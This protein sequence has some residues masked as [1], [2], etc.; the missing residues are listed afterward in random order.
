MLFE[1]WR[2]GGDVTIY[3]TSARHTTGYQRQIVVHDDIIAIMLAM[4]Y[5]G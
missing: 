3:D 1:Y 5:A 2:T 4:T